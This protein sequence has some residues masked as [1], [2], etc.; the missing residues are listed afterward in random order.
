MSDM[1]SVNAGG[2]NQPR[3]M[4]EETM[5]DQL[6][7]RVRTLEEDKSLWKKIGAGSGC[8]FVL[9]LLTAILLVGGVSLY[10]RGKITR[11]EAVIEA[12]KVEISERSL[13]ERGG[14]VKVWV[15]KKTIMPLT[16]VDQSFFEL[17]TYP[18]TCAVDALTENDDLRGRI[19]H[20]VFAGYPVTIGHYEILPHLRPT[21]EDRR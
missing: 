14:V 16:D 17:R 13:I 8:L 1:P 4:D 3:A 2:A 12:L 11:Q 5:A 15:A 6:L 19:H 18:K 20:A 10:Y 7:R 21:I 9:V